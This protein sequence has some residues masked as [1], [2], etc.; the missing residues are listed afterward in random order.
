MRWLGGAVAALVLASTTVA[1]AAEPL[2]A[3]GARLLLTRA[4]FAPNDGDVGGVA[5]LT[6][7]AA[8][9]RLLSGVR[10]TAATPAPAWIDERFIP[11]RELRSMSDEARKAELQ[12]QIR[13]G[14]DLRG[15]W[16]REMVSTPSPLTERMT[17]FWHNHFVSAQPKVR[18]SQLM[19]RQNVLL[20]QHA[21]GRFDQL[22]HA[23]AKDPEARY[24]TAGE[25]REVLM[26]AGFSMAGA[27]ATTGSTADRNN[28]YAPRAGNTTPPVSQPAR[29]APSAWT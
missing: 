29:P 19:Y 26:S 15:W 24:Q 7:A 17:L 5:R 16:L 28:P 22:L 4:G 14:L 3:T 20:R 11:P 10:T 21:L 23:V 13:M 25:F 27:R 1:F 2:G 18:Y 9:D 6:H 8:V 12:K